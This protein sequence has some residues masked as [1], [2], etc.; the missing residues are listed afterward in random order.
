MGEVKPDKRPKI[1]PLSLCLARGTSIALFSGGSNQGVKDTEPRLLEQPN[2]TNFTTS[3]LFACAPRLKSRKVGSMK[4][5]A[6]WTTLVLF[7][8]FASATVSTHAQSGHAIRA[9]VPFDFIVGEKTIP[10]GHITAHGMSSANSGPVLIQN[11]DQGKL[12]L[13]VGRQLMRT[14]ES[15]QCKLVFRRY[16]NRYYLA[17]IWTPGY[18]AWEVMKSKEEKSLERENRLVKNFRPTLVVATATRN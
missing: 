3:C 17:E 9:N 13:R 10:A 11:V 14:S 2:N 7:G 6:L 8:I 5:Q 15:D 4:K 18:K 12:T 16:G 1:Q